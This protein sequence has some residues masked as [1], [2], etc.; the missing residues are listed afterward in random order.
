MDSA[1]VDLFEYFVSRGRTGAS[2]AILKST[3]M[4]K[5]ASSVESEEWNW[6]HMNV[7]GILNTIFNNISDIDRMRQTFTPPF[8]HVIYLE[9]YAS[10]NIC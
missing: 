6:A 2:E 4:F 7:L 1:K 9:L 8:E 3:N 5:S 10:I